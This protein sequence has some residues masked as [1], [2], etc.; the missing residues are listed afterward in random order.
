MSNKSR[1]EEFEINV[2]SKQ[3]LVN[4]MD[5]CMSDNDIISYK[6]LSDWGK[7]RDIC[8]KNV[9]FIEGFLNVK[10]NKVSIC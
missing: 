1:K 2:I 5:I 4:E 8:H 7:G 3:V 9:C 6:S 10:S